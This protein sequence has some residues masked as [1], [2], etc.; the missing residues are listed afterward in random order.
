MSVEKLQKLE[1]STLSAVLE[2]TLLIASFYMRACL[3]GSALDKMPLEQASR[4]VLFIGAVS[5]QKWHGCGIIVCVVPDLLTHTFRA[6][7]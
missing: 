1:I 7:S 5:R 6:R 4:E 2:D 3:V